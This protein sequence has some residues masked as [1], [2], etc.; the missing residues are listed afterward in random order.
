M[1]SDSQDPE[2]EKRS[3]SKLEAVICAPVRTAI[4]TYNG[5]LKTTPA[6]EL[7]A[8]TIRQT[9]R[10]ACPGTVKID[11]VVMGNVIQVGN[12]MNPARQ[13]VINAGLPVD[14]PA[15]TANRVCGSGGG[16]GIALA[17]ETLH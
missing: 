6:T 15:M 4:G 10:R 12:K 5:S 14:A 2:M 7:G 8:T 17:V 3:M 9:L 11:G 1:S 16:Q 13:A